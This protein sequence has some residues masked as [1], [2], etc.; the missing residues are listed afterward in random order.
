MLKLD[1]EL[2]EEQRQELNA[3]TEKFHCSLQVPI[4]NLMPANMHI[5]EGTINSVQYTQVLEQHL[6]PRR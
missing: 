2:K 4:F 5:C 1:I 3:E 6:L